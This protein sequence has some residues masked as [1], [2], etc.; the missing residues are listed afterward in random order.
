MAKKIKIFSTQDDPKRLENEIN[1]WLDQYE[2]VNIISLTPCEAGDMQSGFRYSVTIFYDA[3]PKVERQNK[4]RNLTG[5][6]DYVV[7]GKNFRD[8][9][10]DV[11]E[12][13]AFITTGQAFDVGKE[14]T[15]I[16][17]LPT[18]ERPLKINGEI[19]RISEEGIGVKFKKQS[20]VQEEMLQ[21]L[22]DNI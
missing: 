14:I 15:V 16:L 8:F 12:G 5:M 1:Q 18:L 2:N 6:V 9:I 10:K 11:G 22:L 21:I 7:D 3:E 17:V 13:G 20:Q 19:V 4:R